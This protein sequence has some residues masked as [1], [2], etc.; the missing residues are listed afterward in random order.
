MFIN[1]TFKILND[2]NINIEQNFYVLF[3]SQNT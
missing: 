1:D 2:V 3:D